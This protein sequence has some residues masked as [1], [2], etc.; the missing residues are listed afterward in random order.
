[1]APELIDKNC[2][3]IENPDIRLFAP[4][5]LAHPKLL[6]LWDESVGGIIGSLALGCGRNVHRSVVFTPAKTLVVPRLSS[7]SDAC[8]PDRHRQ[9]QPR[10]HVRAAALPAHARP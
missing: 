9:P 6:R 10:R 3:C 8:A 5:I 7:A 4:Q 2:P 1:M